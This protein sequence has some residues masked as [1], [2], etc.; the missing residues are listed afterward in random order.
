MRSY[1]VEPRISIAAVKAGTAPLP[2]RFFWS[3]KCC[4]NAT[5]TA[6]PR[7]FFGSSASLMPPTVSSV[8][9]FMMLFW[10]GSK[11]SDTSAA[12]RGVKLASRLATLGAC[13]MAARSGASSGANRPV[14]RLSRR[15]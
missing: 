14:T 11:S 2:N 8:V 12:A 4:S 5:E 7:F 6:S 3:P 13:G 15:R 9:R 10:L 1:F